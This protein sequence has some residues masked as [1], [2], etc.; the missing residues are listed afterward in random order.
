MA[1]QGEMG[2]T[3]FAYPEQYAKLAPVLKGIIIGSRT[4]ITPSAIRIGVGLNHS[5][6]FGKVPANSVNADGVDKLFGAVD[7]VALSAYITADPYPYPLMFDRAFDIF[8]GELGQ[9]NRSVRNY[10]SLEL[11]FAELGIGGSLSN[12]RLATSRRETGAETANGI[13]ANYD[14]A[15]DPWQC[16]I[17]AAMRQ[18]FYCSAVQYLSEAFQ[19]RWT[20]TRAY[21]WNLGS[22]DVQGLAPGTFNAA[23]QGYADPSIIAM[24]AD[25]N[26]NGVS[27]CT[28]FNQPP[29]QWQAPYPILETFDSY[30]AVELERVYMTNPGGNTL[31][32]SLASSVDPAST[33]AM[34]LAFRIGSGSA[35]DPDYAGLT[36]V[37]T[38]IPQA[39]AA[40]GLRLNFNYHSALPD[41]AARYFVLQIQN[42]HGQMWERVIPL[43]Q[44]NAGPVDTDFATGF[45]KPAWYTGADYGIPVGEQISQFSFYINGTIKS[46]EKA[47]PTPQNTTEHILI[48]PLV[49][50]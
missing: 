6:T 31:T 29:K 46:D 12:G 17:C 11:Q 50:L 21:L 48:G 40:H 23:G 43:G 38:P 4:D 49:W 13:G 2:A 15:N 9:I 28:L 22:W 18:E 41:G 7:F 14:P 5:D 37:F 19:N 32:Q 8:D 42:T 47:T 39:A 44:S 24:I 16:S 34:D 26:K 35:S 36:K 27:N 45:S 25:Y 20:V 30:D 33:Q 1:M 3:V 10:K